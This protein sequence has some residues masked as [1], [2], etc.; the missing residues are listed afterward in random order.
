[1]KPRHT[2]AFEAHL[3]VQLV[4]RAKTLKVSRSVGGEVLS[5]KCPCGAVILPPTPAIPDLKGRQ[6]GMLKSKIERHLRDDHGVSKHT[7]GL[8]LK[9]FSATD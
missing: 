3:L 9:E 1:M 7:I 6:R 2:A 8:V 5:L 4:E